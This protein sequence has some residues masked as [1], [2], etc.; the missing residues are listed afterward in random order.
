VVSGLLLGIAA[1]ARWRRRPALGIVLAALPPLAV[2][3]LVEHRWWAPVEVAPA[4]G[5]PLRVLHWNVSGGWVGAGEQAREIA[6]AA[7]D[8]VVLSEAPARV[9]RGVAAALPGFR[10][11]TYDSL[12][13]FARDPGRGH[14]L[15]RSRRLQV[16]EFVLPWR[17]RELRVLAVN[18]GSALRVPRDPSLRRVTAL[19]AERR[20]DLVVGDFNAP[21]RSRA[22][23]RLPPGY[24]HAYDE[25]GRGWSAT[26]P[27]P[28]P[29]IAIDQAIVGPRWRVTGYRLAGTPWSDHR[30]QRFEL[31]AAAAAP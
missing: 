28:V 22:L 31:V 7:P 12:S 26:W 3:L 23:S 5:P 14:W 2:G 9:A 8:L 24:R 13:L 17:E 29:L 6:G 27:V 30:L 1:A 19:I 10:A 18:L 15:E 25:A 16:V 4:G 21:R 20:P 11:A